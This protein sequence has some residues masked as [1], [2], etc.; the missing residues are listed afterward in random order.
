MDDILLVSALL[1][2]LLL[3]IIFVY[4]QRYRNSVKQKDVYRVAFKMEDQPV[5][6]TVDTMPQL[7]DTED[8]IIRYSDVESEEVI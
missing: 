5:T 2:S 1:A 7:V 6:E 3:L 8:T 4:A